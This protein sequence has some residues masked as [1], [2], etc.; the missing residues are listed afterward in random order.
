MSLK[1]PNTN[2]TSIMNTKQL[3][4]K[5][6]EFMESRKNSQQLFDIVQHF[7]VSKV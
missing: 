5:A 7:Q 1:V 6:T 4:V 3:K 2:S